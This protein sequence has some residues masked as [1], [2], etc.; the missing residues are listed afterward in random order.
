M[1]PGKQQKFDCSLAL[2][3]RALVKEEKDLVFWNNV[4]DN[5]MS[6]S[7]ALRQ[8]KGNISGTEGRIAELNAAILLLDPPKEEKK[9]EPK[10]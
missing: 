8:A 10:N 7:L 3:R 6:D 5:S 2:L 1:N 9:D 4:K